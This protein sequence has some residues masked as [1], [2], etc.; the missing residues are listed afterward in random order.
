MTLLT[1]TSDLVP[2]IVVFEAY[3]SYI[4]KVG[5]PFGVCM[6]HGIGKCPILFQ[7]HFDIDL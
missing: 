4:F 1:L 5:I 3:L 2:C 6:H 7:G